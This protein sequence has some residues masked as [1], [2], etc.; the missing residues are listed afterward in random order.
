MCST[1]LAQSWGKHE[2]PKPSYTMG[3]HVALDPCR[4]CPSGPTLGS[5]SL[6]LLPSLTLIEGCCFPFPESSP[7][8][9]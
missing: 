4:D 6:A 9:I 5:Q 1:P 3:R 2:T 7:S 8:T